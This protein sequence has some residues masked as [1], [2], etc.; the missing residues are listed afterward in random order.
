MVLPLELID[1]IIRYLVGDVRSLRR[2]S[3]VAKPWMHLCR[4]WLFNDVFIT[5]KTHQPWLNRISARDTDLLRNIRSFTFIYDPMVWGRITPYRIDSLYRYLSGLSRLESLGLSSM[6]LGPEVLQQIG[7]CSSFQHTLKSLSLTGCNATPSAFV[8]LINYFPGVRKLEFKSLTCE[9]DGLPAP[10]LSRP[11]RGKLSIVEGKIRDQALF[12]KLS[13]PPPELDEL[14]LESVYSPFFY[15]C[16]VGG[17]VK[18]LRITKSVRGDAGMS[19]DLTYLPHA[20]EPTTGHFPNLTHC[21]ALR[22]LEICSLP[23][24]QDEMSLLA[25]ITSTNLRKITIPARYHQFQWMSDPTFLRYYETIDDNL[26]QLIRRLRGSGYKHRLEVA[27][28]VG[29]KK[30]ADHWEMDFKEFLPKF[31]EQGRVMVVER[32]G[33]RVIYCSDR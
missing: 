22:E 17:N 31:R 13:N 24:E 32:P 1:E 3:L 27:F 8:T 16:F 9:A 2:C 10:P 28:R 12:N 25:S 33:E 15:E 30:N 4:K 29:R 18:H 19:W 11:L 26:Y 7:L 5:K 14:S 6:F 23:F 21:Q 20:H